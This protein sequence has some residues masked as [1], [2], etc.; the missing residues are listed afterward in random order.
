[1]I[2]FDPNNQSVASPLAM[3]KLLRWSTQ[4]VHSMNID[5][6]THSCDSGLYFM[7]RTN[8]RLVQKRVR[9]VRLVATMADGT[10]P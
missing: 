4:A 8:S 1:M 2:P 6:L 5:I 10:S 3:C 7:P 9:F